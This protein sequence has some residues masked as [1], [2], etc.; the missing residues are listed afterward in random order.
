MS[1]K[2]KNKNKKHESD[3]NS[4]WNK[5]KILYIHGFMSSANSHTAS[6]LRRSYGNI[7]EI[8]SPELNGDPHYSLSVINDLIAKE[9]P[10]LITASSL[11]GFYALM[12][13]SG[14]TPV[15]LV[16]PCIDPY[17]HLQRYL[18][19]E[20]T[21]HSKRDDGS[22][23]YTLT[24]PVLERFKEYNVAER[25]KS[26]REHICTLLSSNDEVLG[27][28]HYQFFKRISEE[29]NNPHYLD[30]V[31]MHSNVGHRLYPFG[32]TTLELYVDS[33]L[34]DLRGVY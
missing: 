8:L 1:K 27:D 4:N 33:I 24:L 13:E 6:R 20:L 23:T 15:V 12:C 7:Y 5:K 11:G 3:K 18:D 22:E 21:Y 10:I 29:T 9:K 28:S 19:Q 2:G 25:V 17:T 16:N 14:D 32:Y 31:Y 30:H 26:K 34:E